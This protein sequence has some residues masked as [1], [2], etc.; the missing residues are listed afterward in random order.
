[1][2]SFK[3]PAKYAATESA[4]RKY[5]WLVAANAIKIS[6]LADLAVEAVISLL[7]KPAYCKNPHSKTLAFNLSSPIFDLICL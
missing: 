6:Q 4:C 5:Q 2:I 3:L 7:S 1:M